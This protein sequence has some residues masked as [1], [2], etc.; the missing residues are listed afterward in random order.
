MCFLFQHRSKGVDQMVE[1]DNGR[2]DM[3][4]DDQR[5]GNAA[6]DGFN[7]NYLKLYYGK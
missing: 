4:I 2:D 5:L 3:L 7:A 1:I 6:P